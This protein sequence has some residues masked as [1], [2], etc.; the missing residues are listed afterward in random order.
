MTTNKRIPSV[1]IRFLCSCALSLLGN[2]VAGVVLPLILFARTG[3]V[4]AAGALALICAVPQMILGL[5]GGALLDR[6]NRITVSVVAD[7]ISATSVL[8]LVIVDKVWGLNFGWFV[9]LG[10]LGAIGD[11]PGMTARDTLILSVIK[12]DHIDLQRYLGLNQSIE[13]LLT[14]VGPALAALLIGFVGDSTALLVTAALSFAAAGITFTF[15]RRAGAVDKESLLCASDLTNQKG[16]T[17]KSLLTMTKETL[18]D[19]IC[20]L[21]KDDPFLRT[22]MILSFGVAMIM[23]S[24]EG[25]ILP[26][27]FTVIGEPAKLGYVLAAMSAGMLG[28]SLLYTAFASKLSKRTWYIVSL[29]G[30]ALSVALLGSLP[31]YPIMILSAILLGTFA[32]PISALLGFFA[33]DRIPDQHRGSA[34]GTQNSLML[35]A[36]PIADFLSSV[37]VKFLGLT[38]G[39]FILV[40]CWI[41]LTLWALKTKSVSVLLLQDE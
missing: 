13:A 11:I 31:S 18:G 24:L 26:V 21:F 38:V 6:V 28:G 32:G 4:L 33:F 39:A 7:V 12:Y 34:L 30:L 41:V 25:L 1:T 8:L 40:G 22:A 35:V 9:L 16:S 23:G 36:A 5:L 27:Y 10:L 2:S 37:F 15:P 14:I 19:G 29:V 3:D 20:I 17:F